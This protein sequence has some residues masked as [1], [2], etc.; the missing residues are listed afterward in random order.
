MKT[1]TVTLA[2][3]LVVILLVSHAF[4]A[5]ESRGA[6]IPVPVESVDLERYAGLWYEI[7]RIPNRFQKNCSGETTALYS[8]REDGKL[9]VLNRCHDKKGKSI[10]AK[11][12][13]KVVDKDSNA[14]LKVSFVRFLGWRLF[15]GDYWIIGL[16]DDY[17]YAIVGTPSRK[18]GWILS[19]QSSLPQSALTR[20][21]QELHQ[22]GYHSE[23]FRMT[24]GPLV[25]E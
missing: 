19:R 8:L 10:E 9:D 12:L 11:G 5:E 2:V 1:V 3:S 6:E 20:I 13:A 23:D 21:I 22:Q 15:W 16:G 24:T 17:E 18:Y 7:A 4:S 14:K 25:P